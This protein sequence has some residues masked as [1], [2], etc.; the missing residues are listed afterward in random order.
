MNTRDLRKLNPDPAEQVIGLYELQTRM[1]HEF[2][3]FTLD[4]QPKR[5]ITIGRAR[6]SD[7][8][9]MDLS[10]SAVHCRVYRHPDGSV[11]IEDVGSRNGLL[12]NEVVVKTYMLIPGMWLRI[13][14]SQLIAVGPD[15]K[16]LLKAH[17][18]TSFLVRAR[19]VYGSVRKAA[20]SV[21]R[22]RESIRRAWL[23]SRSP[24]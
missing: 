3:S 10:V 24:S 19:E 4:G 11:M 22:S 1:F 17:T 14:D 2:D 9:L 18:L 5:L 7:I 6:Y 8:K 20:Q 12:V 23:K 21:N 16:I 15:R 13:G